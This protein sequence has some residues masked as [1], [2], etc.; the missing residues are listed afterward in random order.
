MGERYAAG[1]TFGYASKT[2]DP[3]EVVAAGSANDE[4]LL[5]GGWLVPLREDEALVTCQLCGATFRKDWLGRHQRN[6]HGR[7]GAAEPM[8]LKEAEIQAESAAK[9][10]EKARREAIAASLAL[11]DLAFVRQAGAIAG[12]D[13]E[14]LQ[15]RDKAPVAAR[16][17]QEAQV[18]LARAEAVLRTAEILEGERRQRALREKADGRVRQEHPELIEDLGAAEQGYAKVLAALPPSKVSR[19]PSGSP[20]SKGRDR[21]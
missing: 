11:R 16:R 14:L 12:T 9:A 6:K 10:V 3:D 1:M 21:A 5:A 15:A 18:A 4:K 19:P 2:L 20:P 13:Y 7:E 17:L 8:S